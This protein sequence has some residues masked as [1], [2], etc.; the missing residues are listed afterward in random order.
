MKLSLKRP[1]PALLNDDTAWKMPS[2]AAS[3]TGTLYRRANQANRMMA[4]AP[5]NISEM[6]TMLRTIF[7]TSVRPKLFVSCA[8][9]T[10][11]WSE[12]LR[13]TAMPMTEASTMTPNPPI[14]MRT[15]MTTWP[16]KV[17]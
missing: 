1:N 13:A 4:A 17:Q 9:L 12:S 3:P 16:K 15:R 6:R 7:R 14:W 10:R 11:A 5:S 2:Q 8:A